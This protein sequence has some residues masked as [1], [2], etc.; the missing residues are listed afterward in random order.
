MPWS[1]DEE[2]LIWETE[3]S[4]LPFDERDCFVCRGS[5]MV[6]FYKG[7]QLLNIFCPECSGKGDFFS[8]AGLLSVADGDGGFINVGLCRDDGLGLLGSRCPACG[9]E[10]IR[11]RGEFGEFYGCVNF[12]RCRA[13]RFVDVFGRIEI[14]MRLVPNTSGWII[15]E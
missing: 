1:K 14:P 15:R 12:P 5:R 7:A 2:R 4:M 10:M 13:V 11:K 6:K 3:Q 9:D 8:C